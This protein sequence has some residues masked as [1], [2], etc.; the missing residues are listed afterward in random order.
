MLSCTYKIEPDLPVSFVAQP[1]AVLLVCSDQTKSCGR[2]NGVIWQS[3]QYLVAIPQ[4]MHISKYINITA[5]WTVIWLDAYAPK[6]GRS[7]TPD[8][9]GRILIGH[10][11][12]HLIDLLGLHKTFKQAQVSVKSLSGLVFTMPSGEVLPEFTPLS[13]VLQARLAHLQ[14]HWRTFRWLTPWARTHNGTQ[15]LRHAPSQRTRHMSRLLPPPSSQH[16]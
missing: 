11:C 5:A 13:D 15:P 12:S 8:I 7:M 3:V 1:L 14:S 2:H 4:T 16:P 9:Q 6:Q 10:L